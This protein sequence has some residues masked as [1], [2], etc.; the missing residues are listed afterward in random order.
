MYAGLRLFVCVVFVTFVCGYGITNPQRNQL[1][2]NVR[3]RWD[4]PSKYIPNPW[5]DLGRMVTLPDTL[6]PT[7]LA[8]WLKSRSGPVVNGHFDDILELSMGSE[9]ID[10][11]EGIIP[12]VTD[13]EF[14]NF[15]VKQ[16]S[17]DHSSD[18]RTNS[19]TERDSLDTSANVFHHDWPDYEDESDYSV[20]PARWKRGYN[21]I[22]PQYDGTM[23]FR[24]WTRDAEFRL[25]RFHSP[26]R[27]FR[28]PTVSVTV[29]GTTFD[30]DVLFTQNIT[31]EPEMSV[32]RALMSAALTFR[33]H[34]AGAENPFNVMLDWDYEN[35]CEAIVD[36]F[37]MSNSNGHL[38][39]I[40]VRRRRG[41]VV[42]R[43]VCFPPER[44][45][46]RPGTRV[47]I[48]YS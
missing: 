24:S 2:T 33:R 1:Q 22:S 9:A 43:G 31:P 35:D 16:L 15:G 19:N 27:R 17:L 30:P 42:Y 4:L 29:D 11:D 40:H 21:E 23:R 32:F 47:T 13:H 10:I 12:D 41:Q 6:S 38:W 5:T 26:R 28:R 25:N 44:V 8:S 39:T 37:G 46:V 3:Q 36:I 45:L 7:H 18:R 34:R 14:D 20:R 48:Q